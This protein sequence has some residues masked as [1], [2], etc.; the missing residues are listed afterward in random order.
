MSLA[1]PFTIVGSAT[2]LSRL[3]GFLRDVLIAAMLGAG[4]V[5]DIYVAAFLIPNLFRKMMSEGALNAAIVPRLARLEQEGGKQAA[6]GFSD[7]L[8]S[9]M[10]VA[11]IVMIAVAEFAMPQIMSALAYGF[12][13][14]GNK[15]SD[16]VLFARI[17][18]PFVGC[19]L[20]AALMSALLNTA[21]RFAVAA[22]VP[23]V[24]NLMLIAALLALLVLPVEKR[25]AGLVLVTTVLVAGFV[26]LVL[27]WRAAGR[28]G[29]D[30]RPRP[31][32]ALNGRIDPGVKTLLLYAL[33]AM[34]I[35]GSGHVHMI[36]A[37]QFASLEPRAMAWLYFADRLFQLPL[38]FVAAAVGI[39]LLPR[40]SRALNQDDKPM[41]AE[42]QS[43]SL[44]FASL[45]ILPATVALVILAKPI[46]SVLFQRGAFGFHDVR[47]TAGMLKV[48]ALALP[49]FVLIK[50]V[51]PGFLA[52][53][54]MRPPL[55]AVG[56]AL[57]ANVAGVL[58]FRAGGFTIAPAIGVA[59]GAW[60]NGLVLLVLAQQHGRLAILPRALLR[61]LAVG[62]ASG[63]MGLAVA[64]FAGVMKPYLGMGRPLY[65][66]GPALLLVCLVGLT[67]YLALARLM[68]AYTFAAL[69]RTGKIRVN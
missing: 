67:V 49:A 11:V 13:V 33:P 42:A 58:V 1:L 37:S 8:L 27:L 22:M 14:D 69:R 47:A 12:R 10:V 50:V 44:V 65:E 21:E 35:A 34:V 20:I 53:E 29:F 45:L 40:I 36:I 19:I 57:L 7:D 32:D 61:V 55:V 16:A 9:L 2:L 5:A 52:R 15:F 43:E 60:T 24:L 64:W 26:Q 68:G 59:I 6:R 25:Q 48:L 54:E 28:A 39:V 66:K 51:L 41:M 30:I 38:G 56:F 62:I 63:A 18:F 17:A 4:P 23:L 46:T 31:L 3:T